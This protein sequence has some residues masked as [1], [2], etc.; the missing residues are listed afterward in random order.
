MP[1]ASDGSYSLPTGT[2]VVQ[3]DTL[4]PSQHNPPFQDVEQ[5]IGN[6]L[7]RDG[8][9]G[10]RANLNMGDRRIV[11]VAEA[12][13]EED[14][15]NLGQAKALSSPTGCVIDFAGQSAPPGWLFCGGQS[16]SRAAY[17]ALFAAIGTLY[18]SVDSNSFNVPDLRGRVT[19]G[20][21]F[22]VSG[23]NANR[24]SSATIAP[25]AG[26]LAG[27]GGSQLHTLTTDQMP[28]HGHSGTTAASGTHSHSLRST[29]TSAGSCFGL[30]SIARGIGGTDTGVGSEA[31][32]QNVGGAKAVQDSGSHTHTVTVNNTGG[33]AGHSSVQPTLILNKIIKT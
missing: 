24:L 22:S 9:G 13:S 21:D 29:P 32:Y 2:F 6:S 18:G 33:G 17:P 19:A 31:Y 27:A 8:R 25:S 15:V 16:L 30:G 4:L 20:R 12:V 28:A 1:R 7:D 10:M 26:V 3:G 11:N 5:A 14:A 23:V